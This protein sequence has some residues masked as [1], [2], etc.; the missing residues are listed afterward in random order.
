VEGVK[1]AGSEEGCGEL[2]ELGSEIF[3]VKIDG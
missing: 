2:K 3:E 1:M